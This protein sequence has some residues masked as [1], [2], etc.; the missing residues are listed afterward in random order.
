MVI[1][2]REQS[3]QGTRAFRKLATLE[4]ALVEANA[5]LRIAHDEASRT[6]AWLAAAEAAHRAS[7]ARYVSRFERRRDLWY[8]IADAQARVG[9]LTGKPLAPCGDWDPWQG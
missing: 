9:A 2:E 1:A 8:D 7:T 6:A 4:H 5:D 3:E